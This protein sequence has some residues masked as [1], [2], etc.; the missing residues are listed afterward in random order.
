MLYESL[1]FCVLDLSKLN[2]ELFVFNLDV[3]KF[4]IKL[5]LLRPDLLNLTFDV[6]T[7]ILKFLIAVH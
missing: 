5:F 1:F 4:I 6:S 7:F 3:L 2:S